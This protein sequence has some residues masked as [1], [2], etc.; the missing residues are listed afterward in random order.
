[1][2]ANLF[3]GFMTAINNFSQAIGT[4]TVSA[5]NF[6]EKQV[7]LGKQHGL[8]FIITTDSHTRP[9][10]ILEELRAMQT[11]FFQQF[12]PGSIDW[13]QIHAMEQFRALDPV[14]DAYF[15]DPVEILKKSLWF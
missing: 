1:M 7:I 11:L 10:D 2:D 3:S 8:L 5:M 15:S 9:K 13:M 14:L 12:P 6:H 4:G